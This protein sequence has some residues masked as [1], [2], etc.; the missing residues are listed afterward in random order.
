MAYDA[1]GENLYEA[2]HANPGYYGI[3]AP[4]RL[5][6]RYI[7]EDV[8]MSLVPIAAWGKRYGVETRAIERLSVNELTHYVTEGV[9][10]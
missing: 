9:L 4:N 1:K 7:F 5:E 3:T 8:P 2:I 6:H 10:P